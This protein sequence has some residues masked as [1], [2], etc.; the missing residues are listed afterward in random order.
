M[1]EAGKTPL[2]TPSELLDLG[3]DLI[4]SPL[5]SLFTVARSVVDSLALL[6]Q[7]GTLRDHLDRVVSFDEFGAIVDLDAHYAT[8]QRYPT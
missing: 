4:V 5:T 8:E 6:K 7:E 3:F 2:L 1:I